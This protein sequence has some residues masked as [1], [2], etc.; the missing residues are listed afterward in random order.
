MAVAA[1]PQ[2]QAYFDQLEKQTQD[3]FAVGQKARAKLFDA[4]P[5]VEVS[6]AK[7]MAERV[8]GLISVLAP[9]IV[10]SGV[11][12]RIIELEKEYAPLDWRVAFRIAEEVA[13]QK[14]CKF[15]DEHEA[16]DIGIRTGFAYVTVGVVSSPLDGIVT[17]EFKDRMD[18]R[19]KYLS[20]SFAGP[21]RNAGGTAAAVSVLIADYVRKKMKYDVFD[22]TEQ[23]IKRA[24]TELQDYHDR[25]T[26]LQYFPSAEEVEFLM[27]N[28][29]VEV[30]GEPSEKM[31]VSNH[32]DLPR[33]PT[34]FIRS[35][36]CL[37]LSSCIPLKAPKLWK[38]LG[39][40]GKDLDMEQWNFLEEF[41]AIQKKA[42]AKG[43]GAVK[44]DANAKLS[45]D[46]TYIADLV[47]GRPI[48]GHP[49]RPG[50]FR[51]HYGRSRSSGLS[52]QSIH[53][54][55]MHVLENY[56]ATGTQL[57]VERPG[58]GAAFTP[59]DTIDGPIVKLD[60]GSVVRLETEALALQYQKR[61]AEI[62]FLGDALIDYG[63]FANR[64]HVL[65]PAGYCPEWWAKE[66]EKFAI[67]TYGSADYAKIAA[68]TGLPAESIEQWLKNPMRATPGV[69]DAITLSKTTKVAL[70]P[71]YTYHWADIDRAALLTLTDWLQKAMLHTDG[72]G[73]YKIVLPLNNPGKRTLE[74]LGV[75]HLA[76]N[77]EFAVIEH[78]HAAAFA[79]QLNITDKVPD[80]RAIIEPRAQESTLATIQAMSSV[81]LRDK[82]GTY[83]GSRMGRPEKAK[84]RKL[85]GSPHGLFPIGEEGGRMRSLQAALKAGFVKA[86]YPIYTCKH[87]NT[88]TVFSICEQ[89]ERPTEKEYYCKFCAKT[90]PTPQCAMHGKALP[91]QEQSIDIK[92][93]FFSSLK[94]LG[95]DTYPDLIKGVRGTS[96][97]SHFA[98]HPAKSILRAKH[99]LYV[100]KD[101]TIRY[102]CS[103]I[104][105]THFK[106]FE[107]N[108]P[109]TKL[110]ELGY[111]HDIHG[112]PLERDDQVLEIKPQD[113]VLPCCPHGPEDD[114]PADAVMYRTAQFIDELL[115]KLYKL[116]PYYCL[117]TPD[118]LVGHC[119]VGLAPHTSAGMLGRIIGFSKTQ[120]FLAHPY[121]HQ[122]CRRDCDGDE[123][124]FILLLDAFLNFSK[125]FLPNSRGSTMDAPLV[126][127]NMLIPTEVDDQAFDVGIAWSYPVELYESALQYKMPGDVK[128]PQ[129]K[130]VLNT[131]LQYEQ[132]GFTHDTEDTNAGVLC[133]AYKTLPSMEEK[134]RGQM[135]LA[136]KIRAVDTADVA[137]LV[138]EKH[139]I[140]DTK[141]NLRKFS[142]QE[143]RCVNCNE[144]FR[145]PPLI[146][147][148]TH[149]QGKLLFTITEGSVVKYL[150][151]TISLVDKYDLGPYLKQSVEILQR[152]IESVFG[153]DKEKQMGLGQWFTEKEQVST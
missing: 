152:R 35:G 29:P 83:I 78:P 148:C 77:K 16:I 10:N 112:K 80:F 93:I 65:A 122:A 129:I 115:I 90:I 12:E 75:P 31:E 142:M 120:G 28:L 44:K 99:D 143:F 118:D 7:N 45:P 123:I 66:T 54:A 103:E 62:L 20:I 64:N 110:L 135:I 126:L 124:G 18:R 107:I 51:L 50:G 42:K 60:D 36:Y 46:Y 153:K 128:I 111:T 106:P 136:E 5:Q 2:M 47:A 85:T 69:H 26:N 79:A 84:Q 91:Y 3:A 63:D 17:I 49:L 11:V 88:R 70:H 149:C 117:S 131:T 56:I 59:C 71:Y 132:M 96:N 138:I 52:G 22:A 89:C 130:H 27:K 119:I 14:F 87:C 150:G 151:P 141:G 74:L 40:W 48:L 67:T 43:G 37:V 4:V 21:I 33:I 116:P 92:R 53:P 82:S 1:S 9:Q 147:K 57:K 95:M 137:K 24:N 100:N 104:T 68:E 125:S 139:F 41:L 81:P 140:R 114:E 6:L 94:L 19:G 97:E 61:V 25:V 30:A 144:K 145:R 102:D 108:T 127:S 39:K 32:K 105:L 98:E 72:K 134:L 86:Q 13:Q 146:G 133:S 73:I 113:V 8:V 109:V 121:Y 101:G 76:V 15:K 55:T 34:N 58:K 38:Q 23:E